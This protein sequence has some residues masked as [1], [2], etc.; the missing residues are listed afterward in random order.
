M[1]KFFRH[2]RQRMIKDNKTSKYLLYAIGEI[3]L[4]V[5]GILIAL[6]VSNWNNERQ[7]EKIQVKYLKEISKNLARDTQDIRFNIKFNETRLQASQIVLDFLNGDEPYSDRLDTHF[8]SL[9]YTTRSIVNYSAFE[10]LKSQGIEIITNDTLRRMIT[11]LYSFHY[12]DAID[13]E[14]QDDHALQ[15]QVVLPAVQKNVK[16][17]PLPGVNK[18]GAQHLGSPIDLPSLRNNDEFK[19]ALILNIE[20]RNYILGTYRKLERKVKECQE[21]LGAELEKIER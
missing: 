21:K 4:V 9:L 7:L 6:Q 11:N 12:H 5:I 19:N 3:I 18:S 17:R 16:L 15:Y 2:I 8:G 13:F 20:L 10:A 1:I 14:I